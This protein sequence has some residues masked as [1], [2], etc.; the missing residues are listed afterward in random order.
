MLKLMFPG[1]IFL[2]ACNPVQNTQFKKRSQKKGPELGAAIGASG[3]GLADAAEVN[4]PN[5]CFVDTT[6]FYTEP[7]PCEVAE[8]PGSG[9]TFFYPK[10]PKPGCKYPAVGWGNGMAVF[11]GK[12]YAGINRHLA[13]WC[14]YVCADHRQGASSGNEA[15]GCLEAIEKKPEFTEH[16]SGKQATA[17]HSMGGGGAVNAAKKPEVVALVSVQTCA[18]NSGDG[19]TKAGLYITGTA[20][21]ANCKGLTGSTYGRHTGEAFYGSFQGAGH[22]NT[23]LGFGPGVKEY[24]GISTAW[25]L[26]YAAGV[27]SACNLFKG[28][29]SA[30]ISQQGSWAELKSKNID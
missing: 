16:L 19:L 15:S 10:N 14:M 20:D 29:S 6:N 26:C 5:S 27:E 3:D 30:P 24:R 23:P 9:M 25:I 4:D 2:L 18:M 13:S 22:V 28:G 17:G 11:G 1:L 8:A 21:W 12:R 7:G